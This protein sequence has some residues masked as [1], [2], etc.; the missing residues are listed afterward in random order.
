MDA[1]DPLSHYARY[2]SLKII[3][4]TEGENTGTLEIM[5][6]CK[7]GQKLP[8]ADERTHFEL[9]EIWRDF[10]RD[11]AMRVAVIRGDGVGFSAGGDV[12]L[13]EA[14]TEDFEVRAW[15]GKKPKTWSTT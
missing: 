7:P 8:T 4:H 3:R 15:S 1:F 6:Q 2:R 14:M 13:V 5:M 10:D 9:T 11:P 12:S